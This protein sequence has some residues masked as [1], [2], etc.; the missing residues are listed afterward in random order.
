MAINKI[1]VATDGSAFSRKA[2]N[3]AI[4]IAKVA[5]A[6]VIALHVIVV[7]QPKLLEAASVEKTKAKQKP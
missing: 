1:L 6:E 5:N 4:E 2:A 7:K 3:F